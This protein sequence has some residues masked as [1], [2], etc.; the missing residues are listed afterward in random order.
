MRTGSVDPYGLV[1]HADRG[2]IGA[3]GE[4]SRWLARIVPEQAGG[5]GREADGAQLGEVHPGQRV[6]GQRE[7]PA[8]VGAST[9]TAQ[10]HRV[11]RSRREGGRT[12]YVCPPLRQRTGCVIFLPKTPADETTSRALASGCPSC[13][14]PRPTPAASGY[15]AASQRALKLSRS[16]CTAGLM[17]TDQR[18]G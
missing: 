2:E 11:R 13:A 6:V 9:V 7:S 18:I 1:H 5:E 16:L 3:V 15:V 8:R 10:V 12:A 14:D 17:T 4:F